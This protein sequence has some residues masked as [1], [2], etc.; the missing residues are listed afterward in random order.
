MFSGND[1]SPDC[2]IS[3]VLKFCKFVIDSGKETVS[4]DAPITTD[5]ATSFLDFLKDENHLQDEIS[6][7]NSLTNELNEALEILND[8]EKEIIRLRYSQ[9]IPM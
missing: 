7:N 1:K 8:R 3:I 6:T 9:M 2:S 5:D 4:L